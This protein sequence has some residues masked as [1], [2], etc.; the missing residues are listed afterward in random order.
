MGPTFSLAE[1]EAVA[2]AWASCVGLDDLELR[3]H[4]GDE[5]QAFIAAASTRVD[6]HRFEYL[7]SGYEAFAVV[8]HLLD[9]GG[10]RLAEVERLLDFA[11]GCGRVTRFFVHALGPE[12]VVA[13][14]IDADALEFVH[15]TFGVASVCSATE[16]RA[17]QFA[18]SF[19]AIYAGSL[20]SHLPRPRFV[21][22]LRALA[23]ALRDD[24]LLVFTTHGEQ[25]RGA[26]AAAPS[27]FTFF[28]MSETARLEPNE[29]GTAFVRPE[30]VVDLVREAGL[31]AVGYV[32]RE[33]WGL[34]D[35]FVARR[36]GAT[37]PV[38]LPSAPLVYGRIE[39]A[40]LAEPAHAWVGGGT[41]LL[42]REAPLREVR[43]VVDGVDFAGANLGAAVPHAAAAPHDPWVTTEWYSE[44]D[45]SALAP[46]LHTVCAVAATATGRR[47]VF[48]ARGLRVH[49]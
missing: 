22:W 4:S 43:L 28:P 11:C 20:F 17:V 37:A 49:R 45:V 40:D 26:R 33:L 34:Q 25:V 9:A 44:G 14:E 30:V 27:G 41:R 3:V 47:E 18:T 46:G 48:G 23:G 19:D 2:R 7:R 12:R 16:P 36:G 29:Y 35:V 42:A 8:E 10:L 38:R 24:G 21:E 5:M 1:Q 39:R 15:R 32:E 13:S 31:A 6:A